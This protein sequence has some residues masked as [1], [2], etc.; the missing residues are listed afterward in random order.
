MDDYN[1]GSCLIAGFCCLLNLSYQLFFL[2]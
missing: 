2:S 1:D